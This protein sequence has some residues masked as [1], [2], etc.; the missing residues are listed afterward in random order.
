MPPT[1]PVTSLTPPEGE[2]C[3]SGDVEPQRS[4]LQVEV[5]HESGTWGELDQLAESVSAVAEAVAAELDL[6]PCRACVALS[7]D[8]QVADLN[9]RFRGKSSPTNVLSFPAGAQGSATGCE[10]SFLG[11]VVIAEETVIREAEDID[12]P[13]VHHL[14]HLMAHG[15]LHLLGYDHET[16]K[17]AQAMEALEVRILARLGIPDPYE[18]HGDLTE[19]ANSL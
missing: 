15:L 2:E 18:K 16:E 13:V 12:Q 3:A 11:D 10:I 7:C 19:R 5:V 1:I 4:R 17:E 9:A 14:Q 8:A 6:G